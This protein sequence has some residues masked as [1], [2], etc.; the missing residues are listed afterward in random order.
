MADFPIERSTTYCCYA[1]EEIGCVCTETERQLRA[2]TAGMPS[3]GQMTPAQREWCLSEIDSVEGWSRAEHE[4][5]ADHELARNVLN[6]WRDYCRDKG[7]Y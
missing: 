1:G 6:A 7:N 5:D 2:F 4:H 3:M